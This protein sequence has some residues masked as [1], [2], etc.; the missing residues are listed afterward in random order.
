[1]SASRA[2]GPVAA[3]DQPERSFDLAPVALDEDACFLLLESRELGR[4][5]FTV[6]GLPVILPVNYA[7]EG[8]IIVFRTGPGTKLDLVPRT[9]VAFE[10][11]SWESALGT[12]WSVMAR[13]LAEDVTS[14][15]GRTAA[16]LRRAKVNPVAPGERSHWLAIKPAEIT[17]RRFS[18]P[19]QSDQ[20]RR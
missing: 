4:I 12:G 16:H 15:P 13:G 10:V 6:K 11:D 3:G 8:R 14:N 19:P 18:V 1:M 7:I 5:A 2:P 20:T 9:A 17:G